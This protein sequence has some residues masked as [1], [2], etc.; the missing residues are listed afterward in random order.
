MTTNLNS[1]TTGLGKS[2]ANI[3]FALTSNV[4]YTVTVVATDNNGINSS[5]AASFDTLAP[6]LVI[7]ATDFNFSSGGFIDTP[8]NGG[9][10]LYTNQAGTDG[11]DRV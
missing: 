5:T 8:P 11:I 6:T 7:E 4:I 3:S 2:T 1:S 9:L 10:F